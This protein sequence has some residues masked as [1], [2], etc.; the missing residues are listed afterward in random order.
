MKRWAY[1][2]TLVLALVGCEEVNFRSSVPSAPVSY[3]L[4]ITE[5]YPHFVA[6]AGFQTI[7]VT[8]R[9]FQG[10]FIGYAGLLIWVGMDGNYYAADL[11][12]PHC[13]KKNKPVSIDGF[14]AT[15]EICK[16][17]FDISYG[18]AIPTKGITREPLKKYHT[19]Y[20]HTVTGVELQIMN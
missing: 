1:I 7:C 15:C 9:K 14:Y 17:A 19:S 20:R 16:E 3:K 10:E 18:Y 6:D 4:K 11:C 12:C 5:E 2:L 13:I 8:E